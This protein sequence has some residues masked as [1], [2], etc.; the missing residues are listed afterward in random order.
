[1]E[2]KIA[3]YKIINIINN[4][5]YVGSSKN[6]NKRKSRHFCDLRDNKHSNKHL[7]NSY[8]KYGK[9]NFKFEIIE[10]IDNEN[11]LLE[12]EQYW[13]DKLNVCDKNFGYNI[14]KIAGSN[15]GNK[16]SEETKQRISKTQCGRL[17]LIFKIDGTYIGE[18]Y[19]LSETARKY[20]LDVRNIHCLLKEN[21]P[22]NYVKE[23]I[24]IYK[25]KF[26]EE[27]L[28]QKMKVANKSFN[29][30]KLDGTFIDNF[31]KQHECARIYNLRPNCINTCL[32]G[33][34]KYHKGYIFKYVS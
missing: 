32:H 29:M 27:K 19:N 11:K 2:N 17:F 16:H 6:I 14:S 8:N 28:Q 9:N 23:Y 10:Y 25:D 5:V 1:M 33:K 13:I 26:T 24:F 15:L 22:R 34:Q 4:K 18:S 20:D 12:R 30:Y 3:I 31:K 21:I 7:Q